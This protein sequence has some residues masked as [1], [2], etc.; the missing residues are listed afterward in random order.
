[1]YGGIVMEKLKCSSCGGDIVVDDD[2]EYGT[3]PHCGTKYK[4]NKDVN[5]NIRL[6]DNTKEVL[7]NGA[8]H[9]SKFMF[10][11]VIVFFIIFCIVFYSFFNFRS[12]ISSSQN[13]SSFN[14][15]FTNDNGTKDAFFM[16][17]ILDDVIESNKTHARK[18]VLIFN[19]T[20]TT[21]ENDIINFKHSLSGSYE[22]SLNYDESGYIYQMVVNSIE[23]TESNNVSNKMQSDD[24]MNQIDEMME[25]S[26]EIKKK[27]QETQE[28]VRAALES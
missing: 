5:F 10:L 7:S 21:D 14:F 6:D 1:M 18:V 19:G 27:V 24:L 9:V 28:K 2:K 11:P 17:G 26:E 4:L 13:V 3:C 25:N 8:K 22:V 12:S 16:S 15:Q 20:E 23:E